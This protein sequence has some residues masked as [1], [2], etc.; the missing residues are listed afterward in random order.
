MLYQ[1]GTL[2]IVVRTGFKV[3][4]QNV[5]PAYEMVKNIVNE[6]IKQAAI[7]ANNNSIEL[8]PVSSDRSPKSPTDKKKD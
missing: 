1:T 2:N 8:Q 7:A 4:V 3:A 5:K 6:A